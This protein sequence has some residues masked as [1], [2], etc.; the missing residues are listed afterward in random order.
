MFMRMQKDY[1]Y[2]NN[3]NSNL[4]KNFIF[5]FK[6]VFTSLDIGHCTAANTV[7]PLKIQIVT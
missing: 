3:I 2:F 7:M 6:Q 4:Y 5:T 1:S